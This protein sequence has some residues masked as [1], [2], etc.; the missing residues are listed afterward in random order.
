[1]GWNLNL[2]IAKGLVRNTPTAFVF[3][4]AQS[5]NYSRAGDFPLFMD[6]IQNPLERTGSDHPLGPRIPSLEKQ[7]DAEN[8][9]NQYKQRM[10]KRLASDVQVK[11]FL[12]DRC[13]N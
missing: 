7:V 5:F 11:L 4:K 12:I 3:F 13:Q 8:D 10:S 1:V 6:D 2:Y 9:S